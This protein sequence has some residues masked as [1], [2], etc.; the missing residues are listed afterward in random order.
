[1]IIGVPKERK[2]QEYRVGLTP[3]AV[4]EYVLAH[5]RVYIETGAGVGS[6][7]SDEAYRAVGAEVVS[8]SEVWSQAELIM[9]VKEPIA[10]EYQFLRP[11]LVIFTYFHL[12]ANRELTEVLLAKKVTAVAY[13][14]VQLPDHSLPLL[15]PMSEV[16]GRMAVQI[17]AQF[18]ERQYGGRGVLLSG[19]PGVSKARVVI[20]GGGVVGTNAATV[21]LGMGAE[22]TIFDRNLQRLRAIDDQFQGRIQTAYSTPNGLTTALKSADLVIGAVLIPGASAP[23]LVTRAMVEQMPTGAVIVDVAIDQGGC[24]ETMSHATTHDEPT[25]EVAGIIH[26]AVANIPGAVPRTA[27]IAL[28]NAT[29]HYGLVIANEGFN[30]ASARYPE[31]Q[32]ALLTAAGQLFSEPVAQ[33]HQLPVAPWPTEI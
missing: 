28:V 3:D 6:G 21:A 19:V 33:A 10:S 2:N 25:Y 17:G 4:H 23:K 8:Q 31:L 11:G 5:H 26:Y 20:I 29:S 32:P 24:I 27:T 7:F 1:M 30:S 13:E 12:A 18:L 14:T 9:K 22:V 15:T 16:A